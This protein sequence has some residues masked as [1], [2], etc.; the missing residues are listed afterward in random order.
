MNTYS[1]DVE[2]I[3]KLAESSGATEAEVYRV[4]SR[5]VTIKATDRIV[6]PKALELDAI[7]VR[8]AVG[9]RVAVVGT[10]DLSE[11]GIRRAVEAAVS[12]ARATNEDPHW[13]GFNEEVG[14]TPLNGLWDRETAEISPEG[15]A[16]VVRDALTAV[17][18]GSPA[19]KPVRCLVSA[20]SL[21]VELMNSYG[22]PVKQRMTSVTGWI[23]VK[24]VKDGKEG[25][26]SDDAFARNL[27][28]FKLSDVAREA[29][30]KAPE[31][32]DSKPIPTGTYDVILAPRVT[33]SVLSIMLMP[34]LSALSVQQGRS[35]LAGK[36]G[37]AVMARHV[38]IIDAG[39]DPA[40]PGGR[41][42]DDEGHP[43]VSRALIKEGILLDYAYDSYT[44]KKEGRK[45]TGNAWREYSSA[46]SPRPNHILLKAG[47]A[48]LD[49]MVREVRN[50][51][52]VESTIGEW[53]SNPVSGNL[54][55]TVTHAYLIRDGE[56]GGTVKGVVLSGNFYE[57]MKKSID[58]IGREAETHGSA[59]APHI[60]LR[61]L[62][63]AGK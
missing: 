46:P 38:T 19:S 36:V 48:S 58:L 57:L 9:K 60:L 10:Q 14:L 40:K 37:E 35:P 44:A 21:T 26:F 8:V 16:S 43:T 20:S 6:Q 24:A 12:I 59:T 63:V 39:A 15:L 54:N 47:D 62:R 22:G 18:E 34:A 28:E 27:R 55:A 7:G 31:F 2:K 50:G 51:L 4:W 29:G 53:L 3:L 45:S 49:E 11:A 5:E 32:I 1:H 13:R 61:N 30:A 42:F 17:S 25:T 41:E 52:L 56:V 23:Y 33:T